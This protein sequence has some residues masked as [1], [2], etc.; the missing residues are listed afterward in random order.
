MPQDQQPYPHYIPPDDDK[1]ETA[2]RQPN[3][4]IR[5]LSLQGPASIAVHALYHVINL[6]FNN[7]PH[8]TIPTKLNSS[9][10]R[11]Q[12]SINIEED[13]N[14]VVHPFAKE[15]I[16][17]YTKLMDDPALKD[18]W[19]PAMSKELDCLTQGKKGVT[20]SSNKIF[21]LTHAE[22]RLIPKYCTVTY[23]RIIINHRPQKDDPN[24]V[25]IT[26]GG[27]LIDYPYKLT[28]RTANMVSVKITRSQI[29]WRGYQ[30]H[31]S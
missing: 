2:I 10:N 17:K 24:Q 29:W 20:V 27:N 12:H 19:V 7:L 30:K 1:R 16:T 28:T 13:C 6:A 18:L 21:Y 9:S 26:I 31:V 3:Q 5:L 15:T 4:G 14:D 25:R 23:T 22:I 8:Y 11:F